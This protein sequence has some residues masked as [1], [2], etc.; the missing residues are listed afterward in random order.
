MIEKCQPLFYTLEARKKI[1]TANM[2]YFIVDIF[3][4][5]LYMLVSDNLLV[6]FLVSNTQY[7]YKNGKIFV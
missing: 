1:F 5:W 2:Q 7:I 4:I 3:C 6:R